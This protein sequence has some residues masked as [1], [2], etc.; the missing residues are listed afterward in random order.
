MTMKNAYVK[1]K[2]FVV[3]NKTWLAVIATF[4]ATTAMGVG[5]NKNN[6]KI[7]DEFLMDKGL[8]DEFNEL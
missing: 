4:L 6:M 3:R 7:Y 8:M 2:G 5:I 1:T